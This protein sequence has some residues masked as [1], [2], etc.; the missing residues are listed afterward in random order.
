MKRPSVLLQPGTPVL[1]ARQAILFGK[2]LFFLIIVSLTSCVSAK[3]KMADENT[4]PPVLLNLSAAS[5]S[6]NAQIDTV[7]IYGGPGSWKR[8]A[9]WDEYLLTIANHSEHPVD[10][11][12][13]MLIDFQDNLVTPGDKPWELQEQSKEWIKNYDSGTTGVV[14]KVGASAWLAGAAAGAVLW[15][16]VGPTA[17]AGTAYGIGLSTAASIGL[18]AASA[19]IPTVIISSIFINRNRKHKIEDEFERR[20]LVLPATIRPGQMA[21]GSLFFRIAPGPKHLQL[22]FAGADQGFDVSIDLAP[23]ADLHI[24]TMPEQKR[25]E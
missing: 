20:R 1:N 24:D 10:L 5:H 3:Y 25:A 22:S 14:L 6:V 17:L 9:Y 21:Q 8:E 16:A 11:I 19:V 18:V 4:P 23:L 13:A 12:S 15:A 7:I 2:L